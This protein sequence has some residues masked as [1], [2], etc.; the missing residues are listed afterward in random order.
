MSLAED[1]SAFSAD[2]GLDAREPF[3]AFVSD[4]TAYAAAVQLA[5]KRGWPPAEVQRGGLA[6]ALRQ[7]GVVAPPEI[8]LV[9]L[10]DASAA[11]EIAAGLGE[12][13]A[14][15]KV[16]ALGT[17]NDVEMFRRVMDAG[18][19]DYLVKPVDTRQLAA[20]VQRAETARAASLPAQARRGRCIAVVGARGGV[21][22]STVAGNLA[23]LIASERERQTGLVD[24]D[25]QYGSQALAFDVAPSPG[26]R[27]ALEDPERVDETFLEHTAAKLSERLHVFAAEEAVDDGVQVPGRATAELLR[28]MREQREVLVV[29]LPRGLL[30]QTPDLLEQV[31]D[32]VVVSDLSLTGLRD[33]NRLLR[34]ARPLGG[35]LR[36]RV[37]ANRT[38]KNAPGQIEPS[39]FAKELEGDLAGRVSW[40]PGAAAKTAMAGKPLALA[41]PKARLLGDLRRL[42]TELVGAPRKRRKGLRAW[43]GRS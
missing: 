37:V 3:G 13:A 26:L 39:E 31:T 14:G 41:E 17:Q 42:M 10:S 23:W 18:A 27:E 36:V 19:A 11:E 25:L 30:G 9:D 15:S 2:P 6:A 40:D 4:D 7:L 1:Q 34:L 43:L 28:R 21:G 20:A 24:L 16:I 29:D 35:K 22:A 5:G 38:G 32:L 8:L 12:L 33:S